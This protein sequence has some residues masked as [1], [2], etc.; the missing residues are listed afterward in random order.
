MSALVV[1]GMQR[2]SC[3]A[4]ASASEYYRNSL[5]YF[6][7]I[8]KYIQKKGTVTDALLVDAIWKKI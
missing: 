4:V 6:L 2:E 3:V 5:W 8:H 1:V 7:T